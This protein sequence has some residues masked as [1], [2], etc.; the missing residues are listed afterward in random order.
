VWRGEPQ[1][2]TLLH[3]PAISPAYCPV[4]ELNSLPIIT[5]RSA[6]PF[7]PFIAALAC[8]G[9]PVLAIAQSPQLQLPSFASLQQ[10]ATESVD[11]T[12]GS[13]ALGIVG[14]LM[15]DGDQDSAQMKQLIQGLKSVQVRNYQFASDFAYSKADIDAVRSQLSGPAWTELAQVHDQKKNEDVGVYVALDHHKVTGFAVVASEPREFTIINIVGAVDLDK[16]SALQKQLGLPDVGV[17]GI[18]PYVL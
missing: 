6:M 9:I 14:R 11:V 17:V 1:F 8:V 10:K 2:L 12:I 18:P 3:P 16:I 4:D 7:R 15:D 13:L 5:G